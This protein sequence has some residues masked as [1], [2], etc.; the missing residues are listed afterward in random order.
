MDGTN[1]R[2]GPDRS[3]DSAWRPDRDVVA[4]SLGDQTILISL[5]TNRIYELNP[6]ATRF[7]QLVEEGCD[8]SELRARMLAEYDVEPERLDAE[9]DALTRRFS[10][11]GL[12]TEDARV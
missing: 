8:R 7:W 10:E 11:Q 3:S 1:G 2:M 9:I 12:L 5:R 6:T 4:R